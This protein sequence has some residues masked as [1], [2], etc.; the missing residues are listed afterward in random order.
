MKVSEIM[1]RDVI[2]TPSVICDFNSL[3]LPDRADRYQ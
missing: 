3:Y 2:P 1:S